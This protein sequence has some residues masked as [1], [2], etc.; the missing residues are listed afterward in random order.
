[1]PDAEA[2]ERLRK[3]DV[4]SVKKGS[5][6]RTLAFRLGLRTADGTTFDAYF[7]PEQRISSANWY[8]EVAAFYLDR[9]LGLGRVPPVV[10][11]TL[12]WSLLEPAA[13]GDAR[14]RDVVVRR[15]DGQVRG[16]LVLWVP[17]K[18]V[19][20]A[21]PAGWENWIRNEPWSPVAVTPYQRAAAYTEAIAEHRRKR[22]R[23][24]PAIVY[25]NE[26]PAPVR[27][28]LAAELSDMILFDFLTLNYDRF[29]GDNANVLTIGEHGPLIF[30]DNGD[31]F[32]RGPVRRG[33]LD[34]RLEPVSKFRRSTIDALRQL[35]LVKL[36]AE[37]ATDAHGPILEAP[38]LRGLEQRRR[39]VLE[40]VATQERRFGEKVYAW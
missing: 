35:D 16:A 30:L 20:A 27:P 9:A 21:T 14:V 31:A 26:P 11:R 17:A 12:P 7:K 34:S 24:E 2:L 5:G 13:S 38:M 8:A 39:A 25:Y 32:S 28:E 18:L 36:K 23:H 40:H 4:V 6:G 29:G 33:L 37:L 22:T 19:P 15:D 10:S 3:A 1:M